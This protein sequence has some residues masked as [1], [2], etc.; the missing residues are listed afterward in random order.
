MGLII[1][2]AA[3]LI[4]AEHVDVT[5]TAKEIRDILRRHFSDTKF[6]VKCRR[7]SGGTAVDVTWKDGPTDKQ[8]RKK[9]THLEGRSFDGSDD[10]THYA[11]TDYVDDQGE[12][13]SRQHGAFINLRRSFSKEFLEKVSDRFGEIH[14]MKPKVIVA[15]GGYA[16]FENDTRHTPGSIDSISREA[17]SMAHRT[18]AGKSDNLGATEEYA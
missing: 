11:T 9:I 5:D 10:S 8:V 14:G 1:E 15:P 4:E 17:M 3:E 16:Y 18:P 13:V 12:I 7:F 6:S 2:S